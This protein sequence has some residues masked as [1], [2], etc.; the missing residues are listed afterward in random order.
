MVVTSLMPSA[1][2]FD[3]GTHPQGVVFGLNAAAKKARRQTFGGWE[4]ELR[5][6][7]EHVC[8]RGGTPDPIEPLATVSEVAHAVAAD[9]LDIAAV[10]ERTPLLVAE[11]H[12]GVIWR[13][14]P[15]GLKAQLTASITLAAEP[16]DVTATVCD[17]A[18]NIVPTPPYVP[19]PHHPAYRY[20]RYSQA[21]QSVFDA[22]RNMFLALEALLDHIA[23]KQ[24][25]EGE[26][27]WLRRAVSERCRNTPPTS[28]RS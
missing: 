17:A 22:Y 24:H 18:G 27:D 25:G 2:G 10:E 4:A 13:T 21:A 7:V 5:L 28:S 15:H 20:F 23:P 14:G 1:F 19:P 8:V 26:G 12:D 11:P 16:L 3:I 9:F 6:G